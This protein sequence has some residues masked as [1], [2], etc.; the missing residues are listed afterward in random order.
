MSLFSRMERA[1][2]DH[3]RCAYQKTDMGSRS[4]NPS[5]DDEDWPGVEQPEEA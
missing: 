5:K 3:E 1:H 4:H 2:K